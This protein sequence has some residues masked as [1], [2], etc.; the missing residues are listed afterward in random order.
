MSF[1]PHAFDLQ[2]DMLELTMVQSADDD[3]DG[4]TARRALTTGIDAIGERVGVEL[5][6]LVFVQS[7]KDGQFGR[8]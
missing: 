7:Q 8:T 1:S 6:F 2:A 4:V 3:V 5:L